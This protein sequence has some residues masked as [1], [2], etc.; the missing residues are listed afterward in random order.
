MEMKMNNNEQQ[1][2]ANEAQATLDALES[3]RNAAI[4]PLRPPLWLNVVSALFLG[5]LTASYS[6]QSG[7]DPWTLAMYVSAIGIISTYVYWLRKSRTLGTT[8]KLIPRGV[9]SK[10]FYTTQAVVYFLVMFGSKA[11]YVD[12][13]FWAPYL[14]AAIN[15]VFF[16]FMLHNYPT[17]EWGKRMVSK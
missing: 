4:L 6:L 11:L 9:A 17:T 10:A 2:T 5:V 1:I 13:M 8:A 14:A 3:A 7:S 16:S 12:G 15:S